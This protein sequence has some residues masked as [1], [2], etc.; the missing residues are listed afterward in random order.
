MAT[1]VT[2]KESTHAKSPNHPDSTL[3]MVLDIPEMVPI[4]HE[5]LIVYQGIVY[6]AYRKWK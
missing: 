1:F 4:I 5:S 6:V 3:P 2:N